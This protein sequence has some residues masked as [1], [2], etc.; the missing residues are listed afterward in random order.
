MEH[1]TGGVPKKRELTLPCSA[2]LANVVDWPGDVNEEFLR[3]FGCALTLCPTEI[4][5][6]LEI[7]GRVAREL[8]RLICDGM[9]EF[10]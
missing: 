4:K 8:E 1:R 3:E 7:G 10:D 9:D 6:R 2:D 5:Q